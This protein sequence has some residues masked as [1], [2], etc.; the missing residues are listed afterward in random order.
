RGAARTVI[1]SIHDRTVV[2]RLRGIL[3]SDCSDEIKR[4]VVELLGS[5]HTVE[6]NTTLE[7]LAPKRTP[8][9]AIRR[10]IRNAARQALRE[11]S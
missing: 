3:E 11:G 6:A 5:L 7:G 1:R 9:P 2:P 10:Q 4:E 8:G